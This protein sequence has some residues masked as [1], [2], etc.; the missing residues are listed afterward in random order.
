M[1]LEQI[2]EPA[3]WFLSILGALVMGVGVGVGLSSYTLSRQL[4]CAFNVGSEG[5]V[6]TAAA[7]GEILG[8]WNGMVLA[9]T[10][11][12]VVAFACGLVVMVYGR[13]A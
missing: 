13:R 1:D 9:S 6:D 5:G 12:G 11:G 8:A 4:F 3:G 7:C 10:A 2:A